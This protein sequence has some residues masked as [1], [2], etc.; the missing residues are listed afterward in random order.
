MSYTKKSKEQ[1]SNEVKNI[2]QDLEKN[3][4]SLFN[5]NDYIHFL[6]TMAKRPRY[7]FQNTML[8]F[9][10]KPEATFI[11]G[12]NTFLNRYGHQVQVGEKGIKILAPIIRRKRKDSNQIA[13]INDPS[14][15]LQ[16]ENELKEEYLA[17]FRIVNVFDI[18]QTKPIKMTTKDGEEI[19]SSKAKKL[20]KDLSYLS[21]AEIWAEDDEYIEN[22]TDAIREAIP[23][24]IQDK[25]LKKE[26]GGYFSFKDKEN[27]HIVLNSNSG[28]ANKLSTL[29]H[30]WTHYRLHNPYDKE[31][32]PCTRAEKEIQAESVTYV[33][34]KHF[35]VNCS[36]EAT[37]YIASWSTTN[38]TKDLKKSIEIVQKTSAAI[39]MELED[40]LLHDGY[41]FPSMTADEVV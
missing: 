40:I 12:Y 1:I 20:I 13:D 30:E 38:D 19:I 29:V 33:V 26:I 7:S 35:G 22:L 28:A 14:E 27:L 4:E 21:I 37:K 2:Y 6:D 10:Q 34:M 16:D 31:Y 36:F 32:K 5:S 17:G 18:S 15:K 23:I 11:A 8:I 41:C 39:I 24:P 3:M 9:L 25:P